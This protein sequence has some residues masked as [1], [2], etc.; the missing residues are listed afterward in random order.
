M[1]RSHRI[2]PVTVTC[3]MLC[4][5]GSA[6]LA[7]EAP[8]TKDLNGY[9]CK[10]VM[11]LSGEDRDMALA[12]LHGLRLGEKKTTQFVTEVLAEATDK[13]INYCLDNPNANALE[14]FRKF[15]P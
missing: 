6:V 12:M 2:M 5:G 8:E 14:A 15:T 3:A 10:D 7:E 4:L 9:V 1:S 13:Y 11:I